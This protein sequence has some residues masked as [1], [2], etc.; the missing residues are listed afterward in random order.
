MSMKMMI[1]MI[2]YNESVFNGINIENIMLNE[3]CSNIMTAERKWQY[4]DTM[5]CEMKKAVNNINI[6]KWPAAM[7]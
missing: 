3:T 7:K 1:T 2:Y 4:C 6:N 5:K